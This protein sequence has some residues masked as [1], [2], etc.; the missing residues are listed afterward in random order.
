METK[1]FEPEKY[2]LQSET[3]QL[4]GIGMEVHRTLGHG[5][6]EIIYKDAIEIELRKKLISYERERKFEID[7][8]GMTLPHF[9][10]S[11]FIIMDKIILEVKAQQ[12]IADE[13]YKQLINYLKVSECQ[14]GI[15]MN[16]GESSLKY[17]RVIL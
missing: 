7:Y 5:F 12:G 3:F 8:K 10:Y 15:I 6:L 11:D 4:I 13:R 1:I 16:F 9:Y 17:K 2:P 14:I